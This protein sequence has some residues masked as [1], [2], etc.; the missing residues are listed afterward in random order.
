MMKSYILKFRLEPM[1][2]CSVVCL[3]C[4]SAALLVLFPTSTSRAP[5]KPEFVQKINEVRF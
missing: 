2:A 4:H 5:K 1:D 3:D